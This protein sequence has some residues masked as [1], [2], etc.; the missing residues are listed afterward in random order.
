MVKL[1]TNI[2]VQL[3]P[4]QQKYKLLFVFSTASSDQYHE[5]QLE[6]EKYKDLII[7][8]VSETLQH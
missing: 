5:I 8:K 3:F 6:N 1:R 2:V 7:P 4:P